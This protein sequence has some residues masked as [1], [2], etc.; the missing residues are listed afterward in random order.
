MFSVFNPLLTETIDSDSLTAQIPTR[1]RPTPLLV[2]VEAPAVPQAELKIDEQVTFDSFKGSSPKKIELEVASITEPNRLASVKPDVHYEMILPLWKVK[3]TQDPAETYDT[4]VHKGVLTSGKDLTPKSSADSRNQYS[5]LN[6]AS[7]LA[8]RD[9]NDSGDCFSLQASRG[10]RNNSATPPPLQPRLDCYDLEEFIN[11]LRRDIF[12]SSWSHANTIDRK[13][14]T[15]FNTENIYNLPTSPSPTA[16]PNLPTS[17]SP[18]ALPYLPR[19]I[20][21]K[22]LQQ[23]MG[24]N[25]DDYEIFEEPIYDF[26]PLESPDL[27][28]LDSYVDME[29]LTLKFSVNKNK[30]I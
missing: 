20:T 23:A 11:P 26:P 10:S 25:V 21:P 28:S 19:S 30:L 5:H 1:S 2:K 6:N 27:S 8:T 9:N 29:G 3:A 17:H 13:K 4:L 15:S 14:T 18:K 16:L 7:S 24:I 22:A 12:E